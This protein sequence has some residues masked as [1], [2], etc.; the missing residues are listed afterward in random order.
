MRINISEIRYNWTVQSHVFIN[1]NNQ[2]VQS[3]VLIYCNNQTVQSH[4]LVYCNYQSRIQ[5]PSKYLKW[6]LAFKGTS[7]GI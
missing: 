1:C 7:T 3:H 2:T 4:V 5:N 6:F